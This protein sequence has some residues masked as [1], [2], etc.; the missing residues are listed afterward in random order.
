MHPRSLLNKIQY[1]FYAGFGLRPKVYLH[2]KTIYTSILFLLLLTKADAQV[3]SIKQ[4]KD[5]KR[6]Q[7]YFEALKNIVERY[8]ILGRE[9]IRQGNLYFPDEPLTHRTLAIVMV[10][11]LDN[12]RKKFD[13]VA[14]KMP[15]SR[16]DSLYRLFIKKH[17]RG[18]ADS[19]VR[20]LQGYAQYIDV[21]QQDIDHEY[22]KRL[23]NFYRLKLGDTENTF[24]PDRSI[25]D[26][27][28]SRIFSE[29][30]GERSIV[31]RASAVVTTRGKWAIYLNALM[32]RL[33]EAA[34]DQAHL[35]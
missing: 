34:I 5:I 32:E 33:Y 4:L 1:S 11:A 20:T 26:K 8:G 21:D 29:Y 13:L 2:M 12:I 25:T 31:T 19:A 35:D 7:V 6:D 24:S 23:T 3:N 22:I 28:I 27:E 10:T 16:R 30:F 17:F 9:E 18:Y 14:V 15:E